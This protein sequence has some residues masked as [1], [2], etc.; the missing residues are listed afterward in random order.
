FFDEKTI[1]DVN[2]LWQAE[3]EKKGFY[4]PED[5]ATLFA[6]KSLA[7]FLKTHQDASISMFQDSLE[8]FK[9][10]SKDGILKTENGADISF[11]IHDV[12]DV[13]FDAPLDEMAMFRDFYAHEKHVKAGFLKRKEEV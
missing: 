3:F 5:R 6:P 4:S 9:K 11:H 10:L 13:K 8:L 7:L 12:K 1:V 2:F